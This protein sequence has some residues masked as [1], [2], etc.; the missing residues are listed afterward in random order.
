M[1]FPQELKARVCSEFEIERIIGISDDGKYQ[2]Q[3]APAWVSKNRL[4]GCDHLIQEFLQQESEKVC[5]VGAEHEPHA[6]IANETEDDNG[7]NNY[8]CKSK[9]DRYCRLS[10][11]VDIKQDTEEF[12]YS[13]IENQHSEVNPAMLDSSCGLQIPD[14]NA[15]LANEA[16]DGNPL[17][18][19]CS[20]L[21]KS[22]F[23]V[24]QEPD[25]DFE[26]SCFPNET[27][28]EA[29]DHGPLD[30]DSIDPI[31][32]VPSNNVKVM[33]GKDEMETS[34]SGYSYCAN[35]TEAAYQT[36]TFEH[37]FSDLE[38]VSNLSDVSMVHVNNIEEH[39]TSTTSKAA[40][41]YICPHCN[42]VLKTNSSLHSHIKFL[43]K[44]DQ[45]FCC[46]VCDYTSS[47]KDHVNRHM[48]THT[49]IKAF[50]CEHCD[51]KFGRNGD[52]QRHIRKVCKKKPN[53]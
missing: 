44:K 31:L 8:S 48:L 21:H 25:T 35:D 43:H 13:A 42:K 29:I 40:K 14:K 7:S 19:E 34:L 47:K 27:H 30:N 4:V 28:V 10:Q 16:N 37:R 26:N 11:N 45:I 9:M 53:R 24:K 50:T 1:D 38:D 33:V 3:W 15:V 18:Q 20:Q 52:L 6:D 17:S 41:Q 2:V 39:R 51:L 5:E 23:S 22:G 49:G 32:G 12:S 46:D 36:N